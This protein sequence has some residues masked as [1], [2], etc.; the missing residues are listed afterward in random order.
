MTQSLW[1][2]I[3]VT[4]FLLHCLCLA[5]LGPPALL[6]PSQRSPEAASPATH[7]CRVLANDP[8]RDHVGL[9]PHSRPETADLKAS[10]RSFW[11]VKQQRAFLMRITLVLLRFCQPNDVSTRE[12]SWIENGMSCKTALLISGHFCS[13]SMFGM[14]FFKP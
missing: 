6:T 10:G 3:H 9:T 8:D 4:T 1:I 12:R 5:P 11:C 14:C 13:K 7:L 2:L